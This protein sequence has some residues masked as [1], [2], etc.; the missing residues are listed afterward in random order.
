MQIKIRVMS[1]IQGATARIDVGV[2]ACQNSFSAGFAYSAGGRL[3]TAQFVRSTISGSVC[4]LDSATSSRPW[5]WM[6]HLKRIFN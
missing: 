4:A 6:I 2:W 3:G 1:D 5:P